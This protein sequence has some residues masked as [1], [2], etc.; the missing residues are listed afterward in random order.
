MNI[1]TVIEECNDENDDPTCWVKEINS[2]R[3]GKYVWITDRGG[4]YNVEVCS[5]NKIY[6]IKQCKSL[7]SAKRWVTI[8]IYY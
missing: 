1:W 6:P 2:T 5:A 4:G 3:Y 8:N 7:V